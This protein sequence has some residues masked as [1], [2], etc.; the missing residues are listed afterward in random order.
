VR[1]LRALREPGVHRAEVAYPTASRL[2]RVLGISGP[3]AALLLVG[4]DLP[5]EAAETL[6]AVLPLV[7]S[8]IRA[9]HAALSARGELRA[10]QEYARE[11]ETLARSLDQARAD[12][13]RGLRQLEVQTDALR[14]ARARAEKAARAKDEF[15]AML[16]HEL[17]NP[18]SP[19]VTALQLMRL[20]NQ[21]SR[22]QEVIE[23]QVANLTRLVDDLLDV[24]R[25]TRGKVELRKRDVEFAEVAAR[26]IET[27]SPALERKQQRLDVD[28][29][30]SGLML[31]ADPDR[32]AQVISNLLNNASKYSDVGQAITLRAA[33]EGRRLAIRVRDEGIG[34]APAMLERVF[35][36]FEQQPQALDRTS[37]GLGLGLAIARSLVH[38]HGGQV[39]AM[40]EG[41]GQ[42]SEFVVELPLAVGGAVSADVVLPPALD[43]DLPRGSGEHVLIVDDN[44]DA[45]R[46]LGEA[47]TALGYRARTALDGPT[48]L[49][50]VDEFSPAIAVLDIG[51]PV[52]DGY[53]LARRLRKRGGIRLVA[54][55]GYGQSSDRDRSRAVGFDAHLVKPI[56]VGDLARLLARLCQSNGPKGPPE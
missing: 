31:H 10:A 49:Q 38:M 20:R 51:L 36:L 47:L 21:T 55:T 9:E 53:Q 42:G 44:E 54:V 27:V 3:G 16:G 41:P 28:V 18:L 34:I 22:E 11:A 8:T 7:A 37:G 2:T 4:G 13:E 14:T 48:A 12:V 33:P 5:D 50:M 1:F 6:G 32:M 35:E 40:S 52:M 25:I 23:R 39:R 24:S 26:A 46:L 15:L 29:P 19:I 43:A 45:A 56:A 17:R 30:S